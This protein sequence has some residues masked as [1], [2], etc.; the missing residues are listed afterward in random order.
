DQVHVP[1]LWNAE[2]STFIS[3]EDPESL[4]VKAN[5]IMDPQLGGFM[6]WEHS[7]DPDQVLLDTLYQNLNPTNG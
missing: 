4:S 6:Y 2:T 3:Y 1:Y 7:H 5:F